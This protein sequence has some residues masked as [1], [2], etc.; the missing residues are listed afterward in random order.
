MSI[1]VETTSPRRDSDFLVDIIE[2]PLEQVLDPNRW[3]MRIHPALQESFE[4]LLMVDPTMATRFFEIGATLEADFPQY[5]AQ[6]SKQDG[7]EPQAWPDELVLGVILY[8]TQL[9]ILPWID[10]KSQ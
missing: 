9:A 5:T 8:A 3:Q 7:G 4:R 1:M 10:D 6:S 2:N